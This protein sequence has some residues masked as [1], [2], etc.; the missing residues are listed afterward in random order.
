M[1][2][3]LLYDKSYQGKTVDTIFNLLKNNLWLFACF[4]AYILTIFSFGL[5][6]LWLYRQSPSRY[7]FARDILA[8]RLQTVRA[9]LEHEIENGLLKMNILNQ[10]QA[11]LTD[12]SE[13]LTK[14]L[15]LKETQLDDGS[16]AVFTLIPHLA[17][18]DASVVFNS[19]QI[20]LYDQRNQF[21]GSWEEDKNCNNFD[22]EAFRRITARYLSEE[23]RL[24]ANRRKQVVDLAETSP[25]IWTL[26]DFIYFSAITQTTVGYGD[27]LPNSPVIRKC[28]V[29]QVLLGYL[30]LVVI[31]NLVVKE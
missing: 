22:L 10:L 17:S 5:I 25:D 8:S 20:I 12:T 13:A 30:F 19:L 26:S 14:V 6:Y 3:N 7:I 29:A 28:V 24:L 11:L 15:V 4:S 18:P 31:I 2:N 16:R 23:T 21:I 1:G 27:I 9:T